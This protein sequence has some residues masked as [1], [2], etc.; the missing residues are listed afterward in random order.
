MAHHHRAETLFLLSLST[1]SIAC[2]DD[3]SGHGAD[4]DA[5]VELC[6]PYAELVDRCYA[7]ESGVFFLQPLGG[8]VAATGDAD[9]KGP[10]CRGAHDEYFACLGD[11]ECPDLKN[12]QSPCSEEEARVEDVCDFDDDD[13]G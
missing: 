10:D 4:I 8:C 2:D 11:M 12:G 5:A 6:L 1:L 13:E 3:R 9:A 7:E